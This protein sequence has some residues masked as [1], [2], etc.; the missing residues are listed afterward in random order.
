MKYKPLMKKQQKQLDKRLA[1]Y[2]K[3]QKENVYPVYEAW[4]NDKKRP[5]CPHCKRSFAIYH[6][7]PKV[8]YGMDQTY[9]KNVYFYLAFEKNRLKNQKYRPQIGKK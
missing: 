6:Y 4:W 1:K 2:L 9:A 3:E 7:C 5:F 8:K